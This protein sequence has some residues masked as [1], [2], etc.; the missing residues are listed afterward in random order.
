MEA[1]LNNFFPQKLRE[2]KVEEFINQK[3]GTMSMKEYGLKF[4]Q[5]YLHAL[6]MVQNIRAR[7]RKCVSG[8][9]K[10]VKKKCNVALLVS[11][12]EISKLMVYARK[13]EKDKQKDREKHQ[14]KRERS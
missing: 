12:M 13:V 14:S 10:H 11:D 8:V 1:F 2:A 7:I 3:E 6:E 4:T 9:G 5:L